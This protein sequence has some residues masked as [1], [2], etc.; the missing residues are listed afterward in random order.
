MLFAHAVFNIF[1]GVGCYVIVFNVFSMMFAKCRCRFVVSV[2]D[3]SERIMCLSFHFH[4]VLC[5]TSM[6]LFVFRNM[7]VLSGSSESS[8]A[9]VWRE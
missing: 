2:F 4:M 3:Y 7:L 1:T 5:E 6:L 8:I 9:M